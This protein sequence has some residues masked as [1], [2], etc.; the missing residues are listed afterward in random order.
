MAGA[1]RDV[2]TELLHVCDRHELDF[3]E[4]EHQAMQVYI[5]ELGHV[6]PF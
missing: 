5:E 2:L 1:V 4:R 6:S 3:A